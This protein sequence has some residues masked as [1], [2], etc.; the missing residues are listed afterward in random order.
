MDYDYEAC[1]PGVRD[2]LPYGSIE[3][4]FNVIG[5]CA[6][7]FCQRL[8]NQ[9]WIIHKVK[10]DIPLYWD[11]KVRQ[12][13]EIDREITRFVAESGEVK[14][15]HLDF[16]EHDFQKL[17]TS[18][19]TAISNEERSNKKLQLQ[20]MLARYWKYFTEMK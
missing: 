20:F 2:N 7:H 15:N 9:Q 14:A 8:K 19:H 11:C 1:C 4:D 12:Q 16:E 17:W 5:Y 13:V 3:P 18:F 10:R 6:D